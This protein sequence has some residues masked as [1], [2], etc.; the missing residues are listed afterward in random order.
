MFA[1]TKA[2][3]GEV[4]MVEHKIETGSHSP[5]KQPSGRVPFSVEIHKMVGDMLETRVLKPMG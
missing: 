3:R 1:T 4:D 2:E 5:I